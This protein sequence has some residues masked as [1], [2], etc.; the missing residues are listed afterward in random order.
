MDFSI[1]TD[2]ACA[3]VNNCG[4]SS[5]IDERL[6]SESLKRSQMKIDMI[7][8]VSQDRKCLEE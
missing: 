1:V 8:K 2:G 3:T 7:T 5:R 6:H 4:S